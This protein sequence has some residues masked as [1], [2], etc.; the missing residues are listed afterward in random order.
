MRNISYWLF[1]LLFVQGLS[2]HAQDYIDLARI[3]YSNTPQ[4]SF[5]TTDL[6]SNI[7]E[8]GVDVTLP[9]EIGDKKY[10]VT[11]LSFDQLNVKIS[12]FNLTA[13]QVYTSAIK[14][15]LSM[16]HNEKW[17]G[18]YM[19]L[20]RLAGT[21]SQLSSNDFQLGAL[22]L[23]KL[24]KSDQFLYRFG[25][26]YNSE[27]FG[28]FFV[29]VLGLWY[30]SPNK[31]FEANF[32]LPIWADMNYTWKPWFT[33]GINFQAFVRSFHSYST[34]P[35]AGTYYLVKSTNEIMAYTQFNIKKNFLI[36][37]KVGYS[38]GRKFK[39]Y[40]ESDKTA[41]G[42]SAFRFSDQRTQLNPNLKDGI[43]FQV[44][45]IYRFWL[46]KETDDTALLH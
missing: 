24:K 30:R 46:N 36:Q 22:A 8:F 27:L 45:F 23:L 17:S 6:S 16:E 33:T 43:L 5:D 32:S 3:Q 38:I 39:Q 18:T 42:F 37:T 40:N 41:L 21:Y 10:F 28:P 11:G 4:N 26:Y 44:R 20:P 15:G 1:F 34:T 31:K 2:I 25:M 12:P 13:T 14:L 35:N 9:L 29:P 7:Q 19:L